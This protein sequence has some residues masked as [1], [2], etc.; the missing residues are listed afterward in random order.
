MLNVGCMLK[1]SDFTTLEEILFCVALGIFL[2][3]VVCRQGLIVDPAKVE[4][5]INLE[6]PRSVK[7]LHATLVHT[8]Y[9]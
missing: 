4:V 3:H 7:Q 8:R 1:V 6:M 5:T 9:Y 2:G